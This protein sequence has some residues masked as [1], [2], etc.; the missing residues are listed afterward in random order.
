MLSLFIPE[1]EE[2][3]KIDNSDYQLMKKNKLEKTKSDLDEI[4]KLYKNY[5]NSEMQRLFDFEGNREGKISREKNLIIL[6]EVTQLSKSNIK[7]IIDEYYLAGC[8][9]PSEQLKRTKLLE[10]QKGID[11]IIINNYR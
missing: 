5:I 2:N 6:R 11:K 4:L 9:K 7:N 1:I 10:L 8:K 3:K